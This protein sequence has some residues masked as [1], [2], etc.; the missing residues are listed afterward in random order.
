M[1]SKL[2]PEE[3][4]K[5]VAVGLLTDGSVN[6]KACRKWVL[7]I[8]YYNKDFSMH[9][10]FQRLFKKG[11]KKDLRKV[12]RVGHVYATIYQLSSNGEIG[13][14]LKALSP[15]YNTDKTAISKPTINFL[16][17]QR[18]I[19]KELAIRFAMSND[20]GISIT[21]PKNGT[22]TVRLKFACTHPDLVTEW[23]ELFN[24]LGIKMAID[25]DNGVW[26]GLHGL[27]GNANSVRA[28]Y[29]IGGF[30]P[31]TVKVCRGNFIG[32]AKNHVLSGSVEWM[33]DKNKPIDDVIRN[34]KWGY[35]DLNTGRQLF[36]SSIL[37]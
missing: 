11:F 18:R 1:I 9:L 29:G 35:R 6:I 22:A 23:K 17:N 36:V 5:I 32:L 14:E 26:S 24:S 10:A 15:T 34:L 3:C 13:D 8:S 19:I 25:K 37:C 20:G 2:T 31:K 16:F 28:F 12:Y 21:H 33:K 4:R 7:Q 30:Y 27:V